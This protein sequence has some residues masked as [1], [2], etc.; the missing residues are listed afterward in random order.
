MKKDKEVK[1]LQNGGKQEL[2][3]YTELKQTTNRDQEEDYS[4][5]IYITPHIQTLALSDLL[6][7]SC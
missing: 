2:Q 3:S 7:K 4:K 5:R 1:T 6:M